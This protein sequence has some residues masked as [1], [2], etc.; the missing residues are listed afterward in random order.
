VHT[1]N[2]STWE[3]E[4]D[5]SLG[6]Q[7][8]P[9]LQ[10]EFQNSQG[11]TEKPCIPRCSPSSISMQHVHVVPKEARRGHQIPGTGVREGCEP[12]CRC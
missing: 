4:A 8:Q 1:F 2:L 9:G 12:F 10:S 5:G 6:V 3:A 11:N 7:G